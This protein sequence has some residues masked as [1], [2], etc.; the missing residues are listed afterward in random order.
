MRYFNG[1]NEYLYKVGIKGLDK[2]VTVG[3]SG[4]NYD[5]VCSNYADDALCI[6]AAIN[7]AVAT[8]KKAVLVYPGDYQIPTNTNIIEFKSNVDIIGMG[9]A[10]TGAIQKGTVRF[11]GGNSKSAHDYSFEFSG[12]NI[13]IANI[14]FDWHS[15]AN[16]WGSLIRF[17]TTTYNI[18]FDN[19]AFYRTGSV[20]AYLFDVAALTGNI[21]F[22][23]CGINNT[24]P[25]IFKFNTGSAAIIITEF[26]D[27]ITSL[28]IA[29]ITDSGTV[30]AKHCYLESTTAS[31][32][33]LSSATANLNLQNCTVASNSNSAATIDKLSSGH[34]NVVINCSVIKNA[35]SGG[36]ITTALNALSVTG[37]A[38]DNTISGLTA[39]NV[40]AA[41]DELAKPS[42]AIY[43]DKS[44][45]DATAI[46]TEHSPFLT[47]DAAYNYAA[48][49]VP[50][51]TAQA[52][53]RIGNGS[54]DETVTIDTDYIN[55]EGNGTKNTFWYSTSGVCFTL[56]TTYTKFKNICFKRNNNYV[57]SDFLG[58]G[59]IFEKCR[60]EL[61]YN[62]HHIF[63]FG[64]AGSASSCDF[65]DC[66]W[67][68]AYSKYLNRG[69]AGKIINNI[70]T[71]SA[72]A[73]VEYFSGIMKNCYMACTNLMEDMENGLVLDN[74]YCTGGINGLG[75]GNKPI[76]IYMY[77]CTF[78]NT[79]NGIDATYYLY[80]C[81]IGNFA[82]NIS[83]LSI[84]YAY[85]TVLGDV[86]TSG[87]TVNL[88]NSKVGTIGSGVIVN[89]YSYLDTNN[90]FNLAIGA[91]IN[92]FSTDITMSGSS[93]D[94]VPTEKAVKTYVDTAISGIPS[95][96]GGVCCSWGV[97]GTLGVGD[98]QAQ[99][100]CPID[101]TIDTVVAYVVTAPSVG[102][103]VA[104]VEIDTATKLGNAASFASIFTTHLVD[105]DDGKK[106]TVAAAN[107]PNITT[108]SIAKG[109]VLRLNIDTA[110]SPV[111]DLTVTVYITS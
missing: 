40:Q 17:Q 58:T 86:S 75:W 76:T 55:F 28:Q 74:V 64:G 48:T 94:A 83:Y 36:T 97:P 103:M 65:I 56:S 18:T 61:I 80:N 88:Y 70:L 52:L 90:Q 39:T 35:G 26:C 50:T 77:N 32:F 108:T 107:Q 102:Q 67:Y 54:W 85:D 93:D 21:K 81:K 104:D 3:K 109:D 73:F 99:W 96:G 92:E 84:I 24:M 47:I 72:L 105:I 95:G 51:A 9:S 34:G 45:N 37:E 22:R 42:N 7:A 53:I 66:E 91:S 98:Q 46:G 5:Y 15:A 110:T 41:I 33:K 38:Y 29:D 87:V 6:Q 89:G 10:E 4:D 111:A 19:C 16:D 68:S 106:N 100:T 23:H 13:R 82:S 71:G 44:G 63:S 20:G 14:K 27:L 25:A 31:A 79:T 78:S 60:F 11:I 59:I 30:T 69:F 12:N 43:V 57:N 2:A 8:N 49:L 1:L 101:G 62:D